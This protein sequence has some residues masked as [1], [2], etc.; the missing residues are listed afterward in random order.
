MVKIRRSNEAWRI[1]LADLFEQRQSSG[2]LGY[3]EFLSL[4]Y[5]EDPSADELCKVLSHH[6]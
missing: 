4:E 1:T 3:N 2:T 6:N 5:Q